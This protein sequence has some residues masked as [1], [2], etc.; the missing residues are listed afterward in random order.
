MHSP[1]RT[2]QARARNKSNRRISRFLVA[3]SRIQENIS[4]FK[5]LFTLLKLLRKRTLYNTSTRFNLK[6]ILNTLRCSVILTVELPS[7]VSNL[8]SKGQSLRKATNSSYREDE[9]GWWKRR[10][11]SWITHRYYSLHP[12][13]YLTR[14][15]PQ[16]PREQWFGQQ[17][18]H[19]TL[20][21]R[22]RS[23]VESWRTKKKCSRIPFRTEARFFPL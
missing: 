15:D 11:T 18:S 1:S 14:I 7:S 2:G 4:T 19:P 3:T 23:I 21:V 6:T 5:H 20:R 12:V 17:R 10:K 22:A 8:S 13:L 16:R 9:K